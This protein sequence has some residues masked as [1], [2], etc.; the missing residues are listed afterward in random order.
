M[1]KKQQAHPMGEAH[2]EVRG[3]YDKLEDAQNALTLEEVGAIAGELHYWIIWNGDNQELGKRLLILL[4]SLAAEPSW[5]T[6]ANIYE[7]VA[8]WF[9]PD[10]SEV[11]DA[12]RLTLTKALDSFRKGVA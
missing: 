5:Q 2:E 9:M 12:V 1:T 11:D 7:R 4:H 10:F 6:R 3:L 8:R